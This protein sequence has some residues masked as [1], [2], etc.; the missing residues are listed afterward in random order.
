MHVRAHLPLEQ[1]LARASFW[2]RDTVDM[3][4]TIC[5]LL[6]KLKQ[7]NR[8]GSRSASERRWE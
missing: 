3:L 7:G 1:R 4:M 2:S 6:K 8:N 5:L